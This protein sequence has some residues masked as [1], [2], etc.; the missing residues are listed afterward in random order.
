MVFY[1]EFIEVSFVCNYC[2]VGVELG[3]DCGF[4]GGDVRFG[5]DVGGVC[6]WEVWDCGG[7]VVFYG[8]SELFWIGR[9]RWSWW[10]WWWYWFGG[11][12]NEVVEKMV[13]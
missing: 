6:C 11:V 9:R 3:N 13:L 2:V 7:Y 4:D 12:C 1:V 5:E 8:E 10:G